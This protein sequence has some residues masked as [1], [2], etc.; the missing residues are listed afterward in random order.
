MQKRAAFIIAPFVETP[1]MLPQQLPV[2]GQRISTAPL[3]GSSDAPLLA[4]LAAR[5]FEDGEN[6]RIRRYNSEGD[7]GTA[8]TIAYADRVAATGNFSS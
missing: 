1:L 7:I 5:G 4:A 8:N 2:P 6:L 3:H